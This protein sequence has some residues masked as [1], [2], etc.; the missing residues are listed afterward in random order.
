MDLISTSVL[1]GADVEA[2][3]PAGVILAFLAAAS[4]RGFGMR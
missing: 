1:R 3:W 4:G 2:G